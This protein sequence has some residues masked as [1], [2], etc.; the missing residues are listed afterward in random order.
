MLTKVRTVASTPGGHL[1]WIKRGMKS[2]TFIL[3]YRARVHAYSMPT[4][5]SLI[6]SKE[7]EERE[8]ALCH[9]PG[10]ESV[11]FILLWRHA[12]DE[13]DFTRRREPVMCQPAVQ[14]KAVIYSVQEHVHEIRAKSAKCVLIK[15]SQLP[16]VKD[17]IKMPR[18]SSSNEPRP[19]EL[20]T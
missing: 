2:K 16:K 12:I 4:C 9:V 13:F 3:D 19:H 6:S 5:L 14:T 15:I 7:E 10:P 20:F 1:R 11:S 18:L 8:L 17:A